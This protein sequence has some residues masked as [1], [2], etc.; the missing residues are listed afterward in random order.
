M[1]FA[2]AMIPNGANGP[3]YGGFV[4]PSAA[5]L[6]FAR[7]GFALSF[8]L[9]EETKLRFGVGNAVSVGAR[10]RDCKAQNAEANDPKV[11]S[12]AR[13]KDLAAFW[14]WV[15][16]CNFFCWAPSHFVGGALETPLLDVAF[17]FDLNGIK[18][19]DFVCKS[20]MLFQSRNAWS[21]PPIFHLP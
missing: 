3:P 16:W 7:I 6:A 12:Q 8:F 18:G 9:R 20:F 19:C 1:K 2:L 5:L 11:Q 15:R 17:G 14:D 13:R 4:G 10:Q 21:E